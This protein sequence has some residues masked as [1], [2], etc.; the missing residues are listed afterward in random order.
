LYLGPRIPQESK[1]ILNA[2]FETNQ[3][4]SSIDRLTKK[5]LAK[6]C[7]LTE[8]QVI[9]WFIYQINKEPKPKSQFRID[10][11]T[12]RSFFENKSIYPT[13]NEMKALAEETNKDLE[14]IRLWFTNKRYGIKHKK[15]N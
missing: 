4:L 14:Y 9:R 6:D 1:R 12:L 8:K 5:K 7:N 10:Q 3:N 13:V 2:W 11:E 15:V